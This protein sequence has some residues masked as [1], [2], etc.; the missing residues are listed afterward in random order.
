MWGRSISLVRE[1]EVIAPSKDWGMSPDGTIARFIANIGYGGVRGIV[2]FVNTLVVTPI[3]IFTLGREQFGVLALATPFLR[4]GFN[5]VFDLGLATG[6]VRFMS[7]DFSAHDHESINRYFAS[8]LF[9]YGL[10]GVAIVVLFPLLSSSIIPSAL[11]L[12]VRMQ[13]TA[14]AV[15]SRLLWIYA[16]LLLSNPFFALLMGV[17]KVHLSH[18]VGTVSLLTE[19]VGLL[20]LV[21]FGI[22]MARA[23]L[24]YAIGAV[25]STALCVYLTRRSFPGLRFRARYISQEKLRDLIHYTARWS[26]TVSTSLLSPVIDKLILAR[27]VGLSSVAIYEAAA[28]LVD[29]P[30]RATQLLSLPLFPMAGA[31]APIQS[32]EQRR[33][34]Y[35]RIFNANL[36]VDAA[37]YLVPATLAF[38][39][40]RAWLGPELSGP[41]GWTLVVLLITGFLLALVTPAALILA[42]TG[43][44]RLLV[45]TGLWALTLNLTLST[46]LAK[47]FGLWGLLTG[48]IIAYGGQSIYILASL[49]QRKDFSLAAGQIVRLGLVVVGGAV[50]PGLLLVRRYGSQHGFGRLVMMGALSA[51]LYCVVLL[52]FEENRRLVA[53]IV[54]PARKALT[55]WRVGKR[56]GAPSQA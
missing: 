37:L 54:A 13:A 7:R 34:F 33:K 20:I 49:Q 42:G 14:T 35:R 51:F 19:L 25:L 28:K 6:L 46:Y 8:G 21:P 5:G 9:V 16:L 44:M 11:G 40:T 31:M 50:V 30:K 15:F 43:R 38:E 47:R 55:G 39:I 24:V 22:T 26:V 36:A 18:I 23:I 1:E 32:E 12:D 48:T 10:A 52:A 4:Y 53:S 27:F 45:T 29:I 2:L 3:L 41:A 17:Q 56:T